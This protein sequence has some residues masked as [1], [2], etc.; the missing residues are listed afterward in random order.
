MLLPVWLK[1]ICARVITHPTPELL[2]SPASHAPDLSQEVVKK[3]A[4]EEEEK[5]QQMRERRKGRAA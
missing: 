3:K 2:E 4:E 1:K 5:R